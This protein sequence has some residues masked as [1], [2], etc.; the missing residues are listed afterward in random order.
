M[1]FGAEE[2]GN[3]KPHSGCR[4]PFSKKKLTQV[5]LIEVPVTSRATRA[6]S[7]VAA[8]PLLPAVLVSKL[9]FSPTTPTLNIVAHL[10]IECEYRCS[11]CGDVDYYTF[12]FSGAGM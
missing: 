1:S 4:C 6:L 11:Q 3:W 10:A 7:A 9:I 8:A 2:H 5:W 12:E